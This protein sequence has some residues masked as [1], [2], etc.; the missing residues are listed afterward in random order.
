VD[1]ESSTECSADYNVR[2]KAILTIP[3]EKQGVFSE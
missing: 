2:K 3:R 1:E